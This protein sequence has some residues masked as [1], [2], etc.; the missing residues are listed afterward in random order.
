MYPNFGILNFSSENQHKI[1][2]M[3]T[4]PVSLRNM[5]VPVVSITLSGA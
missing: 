3:L 2:N 1:T 5:V 4:N